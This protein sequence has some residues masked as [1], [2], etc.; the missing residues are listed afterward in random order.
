MMSLK[1]G[2]YL[3]PK[4]FNY[5]FISKVTS[6][7]SWKIMVKP[8]FI[9]VPKLTNEQSSASAATATLTDTPTHGTV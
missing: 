6:L 8:K 5:L 3:K 4:I 7:S 1:G 9:K 2:G